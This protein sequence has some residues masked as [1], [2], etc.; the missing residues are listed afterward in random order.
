MI[1]ALVRRPLWSVVLLL[2]AGAYAQTSGPTFPNPGKTS[3]SKDDQRALGMQVAAQVFKQ[4]PVLPDSS[5]ETQYVRQI[6][7]KLVATIPQEYSWPFEFHVIPQKEIN[8]FALPGGQMFVNVGT[9]TA[10]TN[11]AELAGVMGHEMAHV[12]MQHSAKQA[13]KAQTTSAIAGIAA[14]VL[15][16]TVGNKAGGMVGQL[17]QMGIQM[18]AEG[19]MLKYSRGD[20]SQADAV[21]TMILYKAGYNPQSMADFFET[22]GAQAG[23]APPELFSSHP[24]P[25]HRR[26]AIQ[27]EI[28]NWPPGNYAGDSPNFTEVHQHAMQAKT[29]TAEEI[30]AGAKSGRWAALNERSGASMNSSGASTFATSASVPPERVSLESV[31]PTQEMMN[32]NLGPM[33]IRHPSNW[34]VK[35]PDKQG[36]FVTI[37]PRSGVTGK[38]VGY[39]VLLNGVGAP[40]GR[41]MSIDDMTAGLIKQIQ[42]NNEL[43]PLGPSEPITVGGI[44]GRSTLLRSPSALPDANGLTQP[45]RDWLVTIPRQ[46]GSMIFMVF[47]AP[48]ADFARLR[49]TYEAMLKSIQFR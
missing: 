19:L 38:G 29:Y 21:G 28:A 17:G 8:A 37:A 10:A 6:G 7:Q 41:R 16:G 35:L 4:M 20:E 31:L 11:E 14:A 44:E 32:A 43:E 25:G 30:Q 46:D 48:E 23:A 13:G 24:N 22:M 45:E 34:P 33:Q 42:Q 47:V 49:P 2:A 36:Q 12:Y 5:P 9:I 39:G 26:E 27:K 15:G 3:M 18:G 1:R 40:Q